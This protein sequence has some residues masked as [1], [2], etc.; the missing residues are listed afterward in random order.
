MQRAY[1]ASTRV[2]GT[3]IAAV[4][5]A[6]VVTTL[7]RGGGPFALGVL[8]GVLLTLLGIGRVVLARGRP[9]AGTDDG[10]GEGA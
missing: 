8:L 4:G 5:V 7:A 10:G 9:R 1:L 6:M 3:L 2:L